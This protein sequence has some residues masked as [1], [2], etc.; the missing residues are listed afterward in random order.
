MSDNYLTEANLAV[1]DKFID[2]QTSEQLA[3]RKIGKN[4]KI[5]CVCFKWSVAD[6]QMIVYMAPITGDGGKITRLRVGL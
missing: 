6:D 1:L 4:E 5:A 2:K 3:V